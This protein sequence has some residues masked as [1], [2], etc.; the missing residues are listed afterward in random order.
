MANEK[1]SLTQATYAKKH[2]LKPYPSPTRRQ[3]ALDLK[4]LECAKSR[5]FDERVN[6]VG[7]AVATGLPK[8]KPFPR[9]M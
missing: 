9:R 1:P 3:V 5:T 8:P 7:L 6:D 2:I 4:I